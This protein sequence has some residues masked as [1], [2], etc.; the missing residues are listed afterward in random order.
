V[1]SPAIVEVSIELAVVLPVLVV[2]V[3]VGVDETA[4][5]VIALMVFS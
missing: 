4:D 2:L 3:V 1:K 5:V